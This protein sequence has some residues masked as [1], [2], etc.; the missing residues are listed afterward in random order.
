MPTVTDIATLAT[1]LSR[2]QTDGGDGNLL[3]LSQGAGW[4][5]FS[6]QPDAG[7]IRC[8]AAPSRFVEGGIP[9]KRLVLLRAAGFAKGRFEDGASESIL[10]R[11]FE[12]GEAD[13]ATDVAQIA[14]QLLREVYAPDSPDSPDSPDEPTHQLILGDRERSA[15]PAV[16]EAMR[17]VA[18]SRDM[19]ARQS[20][21]RTLLRSP[22][23]MPMN[24]DNPRIAG[25]LVGWDVYAAF[26]SWEALRR[27]DPRAPSFQVIKGR[28][29]FPMLLQKRC[30]SLLLDPGSQIGGELYRN[31]VEALAGAVR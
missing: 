18:E 24:G 31:E 14:L 17:G 26:T 21:Y 16:I 22:L 10:V 29:L 8:E 23:L 19:A 3:V 2:L 15:A 25:D 4:L 20:L 27:W 6:G 9:H 1:D 30:G 28:A 7:T 11:E 13:D 12:L 5:V